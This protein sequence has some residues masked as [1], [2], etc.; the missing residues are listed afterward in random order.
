[1]GFF[2]V[3]QLLLR[4]AEPEYE[5]YKADL[6][7]KVQEADLQLVGE[8]SLSGPLHKYLDKGVL[9]KTLSR[10]LEHL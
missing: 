10:H 8:A 3:E 1:M 7:R 9:L 6:F 4:Q 2:F 5:A